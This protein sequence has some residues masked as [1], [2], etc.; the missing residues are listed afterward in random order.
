MGCVAFPR[1]GAYACN[2]PRWEF[3]AIFKLEN[4]GGLA[5]AVGA[6]EIG[7]NLQNTNEKNAFERS[8][9]PR[10]TVSVPRM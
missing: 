2:D 3:R 10:V 9:T 4:A 7:L 8:M 6:Q 5:P 1:G